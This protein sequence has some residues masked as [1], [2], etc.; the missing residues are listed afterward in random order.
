MTSPS[1]HEDTDCSENTG[2]NKEYVRMLEEKVK[3]MDAEISFLKKENA[4][5]E[6]K[7]V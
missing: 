1:V 2:S 4:T 7:V 3:K 5:Y 6:Q